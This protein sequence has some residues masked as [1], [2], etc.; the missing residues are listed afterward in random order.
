MQALRAQCS[1]L[2]LLELDTIDSHAD[3]SLTPRER[4][5][6][7][8]LGPRRKRSFTGSRVALKRLACELD[9]SLGPGD[10]SQIETLGPDLVLPVCP[11]VLPDGSAAR[12][13]VAHDKQYV[14]A[15]ADARLI[16]VDIEPVSPRVERATRLYATD[17]EQRLADR[18]ATGRI[19]AL[20]RVWTIKECVAKA[21]GLTL[22]AAFHRVE[23]MGLGE[24]ESELRFDDQRLRAHH[25]T[26]GEH[27]VTIVRLPQ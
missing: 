23:V 10:E 14:V 8:A 25:G 7:A 16:G 26:V 12:C 4:R 27:L 24:Q 21:A 19:E 20:T 5:R 18:F 22:A 13:S 6:L 1:G 15:V 3:R 9:G 11:V 17:G 2:V